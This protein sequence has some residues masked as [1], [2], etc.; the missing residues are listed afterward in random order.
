MAGFERDVTPIARPDKGADGY[1]RRVR[2]LKVALP[3]IAVATLAAIFLAPRDKLGDGL[4]LNPEDRA[5]LG[6]GLRLFSPR[7][8]GDTENGEPYV[9]RAAWALPDGPNPKKIELGELEGEINLNDGRSLTL[10]APNGLYWPRKRRLKL[11]NG[12]AIDSSDGYSVRTEAARL[13]GRANTVVTDTPIEAWGPDG[14]LEAGSMRAV[15]DENGNHVVTF[16]GGVRVVFRPNA[17][18]DTD[19]APGGESDDSRTGEGK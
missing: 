8:S 16:D 4:G 5:A 19:S 15:R 7:F 10:T 12:V 9:L 1:T 11:E 14:R 17:T 2:K 18:N 13:N 3:L 6:D